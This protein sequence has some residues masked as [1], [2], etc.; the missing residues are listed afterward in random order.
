M[1]SN[2]FAFLVAAMLLGAGAQAEIIGDPE[3]GEKAFRKCK[4]CHQVGPEAQHRTGP[5]LNGVV[6]AAIGTKAG[7]KYSKDMQELGASGATWTYELLD[8]FIAK[9]RDLIKGTRMSYNGV[10]SPEERSDIIAYLTTFSA[11]DATSDAAFIVTPDILGLEG[12]VEYG[13]YLASECTTCHQTDGGDD[14][15]PSIVG[16]DADVFV[17]AMHAYREKHRENP[18]MQMVTGR[19][20]NEEI[21]ALAAYFK[22]LQD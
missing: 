17:T 6:G 13:A 10:K 20:N 21:A 4:T 14:G 11:T 3:N 16:L 22:D 2:R 18:V 19:L 8:N 15:I 7:F 1:I 12:D 9:P 5:E